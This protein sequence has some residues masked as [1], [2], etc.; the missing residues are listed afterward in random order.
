MRG[1]DLR[2]RI[3]IE[4]ESLA[5]DG[6]GGQVVNWVLFASVFCALWPTS[7][8]ETMQNLALEAKISH[9]VRIRY[10]AGIKAGTF[11][12]NYN[13]RIF[14]IVGPPINW[15]ERNIYLDMLCLEIVA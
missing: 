5:P 4:T 7:G 9:K 1:G 15:E 2:H 13:G 11:R 14:Q 8:K 10:L 12:V 3:N 6:L